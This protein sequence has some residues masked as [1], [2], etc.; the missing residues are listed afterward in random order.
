M[1]EATGESRAVK[2]TTGTARN[3][4]E[5]GFDDSTVCGGVLDVTVH[6]V[7]MSSELVWFDMTSSFTADNLLLTCDRSAVS[8][9]EMGNVDV[10]QLDAE[11]EVLRAHEV[12]KRE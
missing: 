5:L 8:S 7:P 9:S 6:A 10:D 4:L 11:V 3:P 1:N 2:S 12:V